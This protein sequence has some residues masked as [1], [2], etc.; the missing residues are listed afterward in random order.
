MKLKFTILAI[1]FACQL[2]AKHLPLTVGAES[3]IL[4][5]A[6]TGT[7]LYEKNAYSTQY[8]A[9]LTKIATCLYA[10]HLAGDNLALVCTAERDSVATIGEHEQQK[11]N[12]KLPAYWLTPQSSHIGIKTG[13]KMSLKD[14]LYGM[15]IAS[16]GDAS[17]VIA[18]NLGGTVPDYMHDV[19]DY[20]ASIGCTNTHFM[21]PHGL[22]HPDHITTAHDLAHMTRTAMM[23][24]TFR[25]IVKT[26][27]YPRPKTNKQE[28]TTL[29]QTNRL[30]KKGKYYYSKAIGVKTGFTTPAQSCLVAAAKQ[31]DRTLI[32]VVLKN[33]DRDT[34]FLEVKAM[35]EKA[36]QET[37]VSKILIKE[38]SQKHTLNLKGAKDVV[39]T[40]VEEAAAI[41]YYPSEEPKLKS[42]LAWDDLELP[43]MK[44]DRVGEIAIKDERGSVIK[45]TILYSQEDVNHTFWAKM[46]A[47]PLY[48]VIGGLVVVLLLIWL[49][50]RLLTKN[51]ATGV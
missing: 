45:K 31:N 19:N 34:M 51:K 36:F 24:P 32:A 30:L 9:S 12:Y 23:L 46:L 17:N 10:L 14:L 41:S 48:L 38:G 27:S 33:P 39:K 21:N 42:Y 11:S 49:G 35:F 18:Q 3:A 50:V 5:N 28:S 37:K 2:T 43:I 15:M 7:I 6:D 20:L 40:Y 1:L 29:V 47:Q 16:G 26:T 13:E 8:P 25:Q 22:H 4:I 44:G